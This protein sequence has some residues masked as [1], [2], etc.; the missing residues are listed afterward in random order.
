MTGRT[1]LSRKA[2]LILLALSL[3]GL[4]MTSGCLRKSTP[5]QWSGV[6]KAAGLE[7]PAGTRE[8]ERLQGDATLLNASVEKEAAVL[9]ELV[10]HLPNSAPEALEAAAQLLQSRHFLDARRVLRQL[11][12]F[13]PLHPQEN[14]RAAELWLQAGGTQEAQAH[15]QL[16][17]EEQPEDA[18][19]LRAWASAQVAM[20]LPEEGLRTMMRA[21]RASPQ[22]FGLRRSA[23]L[24]AI[25]L[26]MSEEALPLLVSLSPEAA[27]R[28]HREM[29]ALHVR[30]GDYRQ[31]C[32]RL[33]SILSPAQALNALGE[34]LADSQQWPLAYQAFQT[35][36]AD[37]PDNPAILLNLREA[38]WH[39]P[40][41]ASIDAQL[42]AG[43]C[44]SFLGRAARL[45]AAPPE[46]TRLAE[47]SPPAGAEL[48][49][50]EKEGL[51]KTVFAF[52]SQAIS[53]SLFKFDT[54]SASKDQTPEKGQARGDR[55]REP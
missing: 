27:P 4:L 31:A 11:D 3:L 9:T 49:P 28:V 2:A 25:G 38:G 34:M 12:R 6:E 43:G 5:M 15:L 46:A 26:G 50:L 35:A 13:A 33:L 14:R 21:S 45:D 37:A 51:E 32:L 29:A 39:F 40:P 52:P 7:A 36:L 20:G 23:A 18:S 24:L 10:D 55:Y 16:A 42:L 30:Q 44:R 47:S 19:T 22:D 1:K 8:V 41:P 17:L 54:H 48:Q 53:N